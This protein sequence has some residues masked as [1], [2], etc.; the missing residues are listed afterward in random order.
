MSSS[1][2]TFTP[3]VGTLDGG[4]SIGSMSPEGVATTTADEVEAD[5]PSLA[6]VYE[7]GTSE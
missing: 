1:V 3:L 2:T 5:A 4:A 7:G 6:E